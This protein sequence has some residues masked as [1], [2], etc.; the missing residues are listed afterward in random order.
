MRVCFHA[1]A[2]LMLAAV[3]GA[4][5]TAADMSK[6]LHVAFPVAENGFDPQVV[7]DTYSF[8][9]CRAIFEP[10]YAY[11]YFARPVRL[12]PHAADPLQPARLRVHVVACDRSIRS[13]RARGRRHVQGLEQPSH[14]APRRHRPVSA[15]AMGPRTTD[16]ARGESLVPR[17]P[18][19]GARAGERS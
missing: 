15:Q 13:R 1:L 2:V 8:D 6:T 18:L 11:D 7:Y 19:P 10:L 9:V 14:G 5:A 12:I 17:S 3:A 4:T 16:R